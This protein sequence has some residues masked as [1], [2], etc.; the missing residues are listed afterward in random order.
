M[1]H[2]PGLEPE[3]QKQA[4]P[5]VILCGKFALVENHQKISFSHCLLLVF[6]LGCQVM[7]HPDVTSVL[8]E[9]LSAPADVV[10]ALFLNMVF[11]F[12]AFTS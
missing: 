3:I 6:F 1:N 5:I 8:D 4:R 10:M 2:L 12:L 9:I 11:C 7:Q